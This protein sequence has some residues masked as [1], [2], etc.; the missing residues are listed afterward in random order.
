MS[1]VFKFKIIICCFCLSFFSCN[2]NL[3]KEYDEEGRLIKVY[4]EINGKI[5][6]AYKE[7]YASGNLKV[8]KNFKNGFVRDTSFFYHD[9]SNEHIAAIVVFL[10]G[11]INKKT[12]YYLNGKIKDEGFINNEGKKKGNWNFY[13]KKGN[14]KVQDE[15]FIINGDEYLNQS[16]AYDENKE[17]LFSKTKKIDVQIFSDSISM[18]EPIQ[19]LACIDIGHFIG[20][21]TQGKVYLSKGY[22]NEINED[23]SN[24][25]EIELEAF[26]NLG[27]DSVN[28]SSFRDFNQDKC[29]AFGKWFDKKGINILRGIIV[30]YYKDSI[31]EKE[32]KFYFEKEI[33]VKD[34]IGN[35]PDL[36][37]NHS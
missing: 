15:Y 16:I 37:E 24:L 21:K 33:F 22:G 20:A 29:I 25:N 10:D 8:I 26:N 28:G 11:N 6:G 18:N 31:Q 17:I 30:E 3:K 27:K 34:S 13:D 14:L 36:K 4:N 1:R 2:K 23:F 35:I 19:A 9:K 5:E 32:H 12:S 7:Y